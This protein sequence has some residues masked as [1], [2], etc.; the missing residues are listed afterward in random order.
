MNLE[1][2][3]DQ[4]AALLRELDDIID[5]DRYFLLPPLWTYEPRRWGD[6]VDAANL[7]W[8]N[9]RTSTPHPVEPLG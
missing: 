1:L 9:T 4:A 5:G 3:D 6:I 8:A 7:T 2:T